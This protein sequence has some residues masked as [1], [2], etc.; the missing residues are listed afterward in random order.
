MRDRRFPECRSTHSPRWFIL[1]IRA[2]LHSHRHVLVVHSPASGAVRAAITT[3]PVGT[4]KR[5]DRAYQRCSSNSKIQSDSA[6]RKN[7]ISGVHPASKK[8]WVRARTLK[9]EGV[10]KACLAWRSPLRV[11]HR[12]GTRRFFRSPKVLCLWGFLHPG[13]QWKRV[14]PSPPVLTFAAADRH[15]LLR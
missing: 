2:G 9:K 12:G 14:P 6:I 5:A 10:E 1:P 11:V 13:G 15:K 3:S 4:D 7:E 8:H